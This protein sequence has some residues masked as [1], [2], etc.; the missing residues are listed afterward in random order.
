MLSHDPQLG[1]FQ[2]SGQVFFAGLLFHSMA[3]LA[4]WLF[5]TQ[6]DN[7]GRHFI[8]PLGVPGI[9]WIIYATLASVPQRNQRAG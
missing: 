1:D 4:L 3:V 7:F 6:S 5:V 8:L 9:L 2:W